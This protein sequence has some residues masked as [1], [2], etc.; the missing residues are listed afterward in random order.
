MIA[1]FLI[2]RRILRLVHLACSIVKLD[3]IHTRELINDD[4]KKF[5]KSKIAITGDTFYEHKTR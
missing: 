1:H 5:Y 4:S 2:L 3:A